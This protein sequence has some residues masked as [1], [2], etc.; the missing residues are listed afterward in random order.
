MRRKQKGLLSAVSEESLK[1]AAGNDVTDYA[2]ASLNSRRSSVACHSTTLG[3]VDLEYFSAM[4][5]ALASVGERM[6]PASEP[7]LYEALKRA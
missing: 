2:R 1:S 4:M 6:C 3:L 7:P 5:R